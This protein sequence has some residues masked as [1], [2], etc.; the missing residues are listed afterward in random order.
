MLPGGNATIVNGIGTSDPQPNPNKQALLIA[1]GGDQASIESF[2]GL[3]SNTLGGVADDGNADNGTEN[4]TDGSAIKKT[5]N[6]NAGDVLTVKFNF[7]EDENDGGEEGDEAPSFQDFAFIVIGGEVFR[8]SNVGE[9]DVPSSA[10]S[11]GFSWDEESGYL[12]FTYTFTAS[13]PVQVGFGVMDES[14]EVVDPGLL[15]DELKI[16][17]GC[18]GAIDEDALPNGIEGGPGDGV[19][20][21][22]VG[23]TIKFDF[24]VDRPGLLSIDGLTIADDKGA[25]I[26]FADLKTADG[27]GVEWGSKS[28]PDA[29]GWV[30]WTAIEDGTDDPVFVFKLDTSGPGQGD[31]VF[32][33]KQALDHPFT[34]DPADPVDTNTAWEDNLD[35]NFNVKKYRRHGDWTSGNVKISVDNDSPTFC[36][37]DFGCDNDSKHGVGLIDEDKLDPNGNHDWA[38]GD[39]KGGTHVDGKINFKFGADQ[40][41]TLTV[42][43]LTIKDCANPANIILAIELNETGEPVVTSGELRTADG[44]PIEIVKS[45]PDSDGIVTWQG[46]V[47]GSDPAQEA[48]K[49]T[50]DTAGDN[51]GDFDFCLSLPLEHPYQDFD[52]KNDGPEKSFE[53]NL[54]FDFT[55]IGTDADGDAATGH[56]KINVDDD[57]PKAECDVDCVTEGET[58]GE[59]N[60]ATGNVVT[61]VD[62]GLGNDDNS[63]DGNA[64]NPGAD[65]PYTISKLAHATARPTRWSTR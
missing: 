21:T 24:G 11:G 55:I 13:G 26:A 10:N 40:P 8:L 41:G 63:L 50:V 19:G 58:D 51:I 48:F 42:A 25:A 30:T 44:Q 23:G 38:P 59:P 9:A 20:G 31:F 29:D 46:I 62:G 45:G 28:G 7:L 60:Y 47:A 56:I 65:Q 3:P 22:S 14:D 64:D 61:G 39:D 18:E 36:S 17:P 2:F 32:E 12:T 52:S 37:V 53:D 16:G 6:V 15:I 57:S 1:Q 54:K 5:F 35:F 34:D 4:P 43:G 33:L 49:L 27:N